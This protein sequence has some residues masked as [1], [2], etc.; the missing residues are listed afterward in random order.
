MQVNSASSLNA[1]VQQALKNQTQP[2]PAPAAKP[3]PVAAGGGDADGDN[4]GSKGG[5]L[6]VKA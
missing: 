6:N 1:L 2:T 4:D 5:S 3:A